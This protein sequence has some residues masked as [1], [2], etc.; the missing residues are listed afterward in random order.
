MAC[1]T[2]KGLVFILRVTDGRESQSITFS[3]QEEKKGHI[4]GF[5]FVLDNL[6]ENDWRK[7]RMETNRTIKIQS[8]ENGSLSKAKPVESVGSRSI[9]PGTQGKE[10]I[11]NEIS[12][13]YLQLFH[14]PLCL[15][16]SEYRL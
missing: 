14:A 7:T 3:G 10:K 6:D 4:W 8:R 9:P 13:L 11:K 1:R 2:L 5:L 15:Q 16:V 12:G